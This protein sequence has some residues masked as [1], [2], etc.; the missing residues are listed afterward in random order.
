MN[1]EDG[2][3]DLA[4]LDP[5]RDTVR[6]ERMVAGITAAAAPELARRARLPAPGMM[7]LLA[8]WVRP[9][10][11]AAAVMAAAA[12]AFLLT[13]TQSAAET[14]SLASEMGYSTSVVS[15][16][17]SESAPSVEEMVLDLE[18]AAQ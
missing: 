15:W 1:I 2:F 11:S 9:T 6:W 5:T 8:D 10:L 13:G 4:P 18:G 12:G 16:V 3:R 14:G 17:D 7:M